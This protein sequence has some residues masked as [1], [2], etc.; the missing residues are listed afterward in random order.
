MKFSTTWSSFGYPDSLTMQAETE[1][2]K[3]FLGGVAGSFARGD[4]KSVGITSTERVP[5]TLNFSKDGKETN[6]SIEPPK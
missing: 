6:V 3:R 1:E 5:L 4:L 2:E